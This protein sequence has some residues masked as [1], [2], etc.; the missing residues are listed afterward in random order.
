MIAPLEIGE[1]SFILRSYLDHINPP[2]TI[3]DIKGDERVGCILPLMPIALARSIFNMQVF[4]M[5]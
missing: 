4:Y 2:I 1:C 3:R 5:L